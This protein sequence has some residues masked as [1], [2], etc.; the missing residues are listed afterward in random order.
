MQA[1][2]R[3]RDGPTAARVRKGASAILSARPQC[4]PSPTAWESGY[5][6]A[7]VGVRAVLA[8][9]AR[10]AGEGDGGAGVLADRA[11]GLQL[12]GS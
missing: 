10:S 9:S 1:S 5:P 3:M 2:R 11:G 4:L 7:G 12:F 6:L 8:P